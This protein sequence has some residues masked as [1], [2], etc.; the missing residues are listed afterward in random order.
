MVLIIPNAMNYPLKYLLAITI[1]SVV[2]GVAFGLPIDI[3]K[4]L[5]YD[6]LK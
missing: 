4:G 5:W 1:G 3:I 6:L 2:T